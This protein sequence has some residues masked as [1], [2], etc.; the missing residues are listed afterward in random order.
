MTGTDLF[1]SRDGSTTESP[2][3][4]E[5]HTRPTES[6][7][8]DECRFTPWVLCSPSSFPYSRTSALAG[9][10]P[11]SCLRF[12]RKTWLDVAIHREPFPSSA[13]PRIDSHNSL[14]PGKKLR[15]PRESRK[16]KPEV[17]PI[18]RM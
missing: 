1:V 7:D 16:A 14:G 2:R 9:A 12:A 10:L 17:V 8:T 3:R 11:N 5:N 18:H 13:S 6:A 4:N 15:I